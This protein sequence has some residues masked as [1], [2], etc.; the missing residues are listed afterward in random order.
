MNIFLEIFQLYDEIG[1]NNHQFFFH[2]STDSINIIDGILTKKWEEKKDLQNKIF[3][4]ACKISQLKMK[5][6]SY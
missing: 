6:F 2:F 3:R 1:V 5:S 4:W